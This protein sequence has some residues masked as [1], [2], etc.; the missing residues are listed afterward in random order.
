MS[1][2][3]KKSRLV[4]FE[5][6]KNEIE[7]ANKIC[8]ISHR[9]PDGDAV[10]ANLALRAYLEKKG[11]NVV[12]ACV[13]PI[14]KNS[15]FLLNAKSFQLDFNY[16]DFDLFIS[17]DCA[18]VYLMK[19]HE[20]K[21]ELL[22]GEKPFIN[23]DHHS[24]NDNFG[25]IN[26]VDED[27]PATCMILYSFFNYCK[28]EID[29]ETATCLLH[30]IYFDTGSL[31][32]SNTNEEVFEVCG[33]LVKKGADLKKIVK[34]L[35]KTIEVNKLRLWGRILERAYVNPDSVVV[36]AV[37][38]DDFSALNADPKDTGGAIDYLNAVPDTKYCVL[39]SEDDKGIVKGSIRTQ[40][41]DINVSDVASKFG[42]GGHPK[43]SGFGM[44]GRLKPV[45][46]W[47]IIN[48]NE[49]ETNFEF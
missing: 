8:I 36:S 2:K 23:I 38:K 12:S 24:S 3:N 25:T 9:S 32:H 49:P 16:E 20:N 26:V 14:P 27:A 39:L 30:G 28:W 6:A 34:K 44:S 21:P 35:F 13:D 41:E 40:R 7:K 4:N 10:G 37:N 19:F 1:L 15:D 29:R 47:Q 11:K 48:E 45:L 42:G 18:A 31:M 33:E 43:A 22:S 46:K 17:V 5:K